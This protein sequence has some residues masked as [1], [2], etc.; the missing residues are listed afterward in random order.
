M[1]PAGKPPIGFLDR[2]ARLIAGAGRPAAVAEPVGTY[3]IHRPPPFAVAGTA[4]DADDAADRQRAVAGSEVIL[5][6]RP[7]AAPNVAIATLGHGCPSIGAIK[8]IATCNRPSGKLDARSGQGRMQ[9]CRFG[10]DRLRC[11]IKPPRN[12][13]DMHVF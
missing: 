12:Q 1:S 13:A 8:A 2:P 5:L 11:P 7:C 10:P 6:V 9:L 3:R 4:F